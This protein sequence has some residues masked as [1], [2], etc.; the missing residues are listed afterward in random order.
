MLA[1]TNEAILQ[2]HYDYLREIHQGNDEAYRAE[3]NR[4]REQYIKP[5]KELSV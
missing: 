5:L 2:N 4:R 1:R 3:K